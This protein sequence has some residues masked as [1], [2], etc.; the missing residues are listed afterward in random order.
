MPTAN[1]LF[2]QRVLQQPGV[3]RKLLDVAQRKAAQARL[4][5]GREDPNAHVPWKC[6]PGPAR[7]AGRMRGSRFLR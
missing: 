7:R 1:Y 3:R 2:V 5:A 4:I 6:R